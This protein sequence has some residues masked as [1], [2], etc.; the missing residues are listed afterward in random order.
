MVTI[1]RPKAPKAK[2]HKR[3]RKGSKY[4][5]RGVRTANRKN[6]TTIVRT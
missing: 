5:A 6:T 3:P 4:R 1:T 2:K